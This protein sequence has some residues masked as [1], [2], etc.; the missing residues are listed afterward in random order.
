MIYYPDTSNAQFVAVA[1]TAS[2][3]GAGLA[4]HMTYVLVSTTNAWIRQGSTYLLT[5]TTKANAVDGDKYVITIDGVA[6]TYEM[7]TVPNGVTSGNVL[8]DISA[9]TTAASVAAILRTAI[10]ANQSSLVVTDNSD[11]TLTITA[12]IKTMTIV[13]QVSHAS[14][15]AAVAAVPAAA[16]AGSMFIPANVQVLITGS[17]GP[18]IGIIR[19]TADGSASLT[20]VYEI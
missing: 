9:A 19:N 14:G 8:V 2:A 7:D 12:P 16:A 1:S 17:L 11:G 5:C 4:A 18:Q 6:K 13:E 15:L 20:P 10:L 3:L